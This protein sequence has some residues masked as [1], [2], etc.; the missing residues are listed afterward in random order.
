MST[1]T[2]TRDDAVLLTPAEVARRANVC[3]E[4][5]Y[6]IID[7]GELRVFHVGRQV[8]IDP[9]DFRNYLERDGA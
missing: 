4:T 3:R 6:R 2:P 7:R 8:R 9:A 5:I 1:Q